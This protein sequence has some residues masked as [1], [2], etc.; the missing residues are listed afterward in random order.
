MEMELIAKDAEMMEMEIEHSIELDQKNDEIITLRES[1]RRDQKAVND[2]S[3]Y[4]PIYKLLLLS[5]LTS[6]YVIKAFGIEITG[7]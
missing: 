7:I 3:D 6:L 5:F 2:V 4:V 1:K